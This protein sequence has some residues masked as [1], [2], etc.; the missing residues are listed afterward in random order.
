[1]AKIKESIKIKVLLINKK[2]E[3]LKKKEKNLNEFKNNRWIVNN[4]IQD[5]F[6]NLNTQVLPSALALV[7]NN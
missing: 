2:I 1:L 5:L 3:E 7:K 6:K 4:L